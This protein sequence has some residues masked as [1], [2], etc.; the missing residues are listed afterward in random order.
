MSIKRTQMGVSPCIGWKAVLIVGGGQAAR[1][2]NVSRT[3]SH[4]LSPKDMENLTTYL[5][6]DPAGTSALRHG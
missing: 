5:S 1:A 2:R 3:G 6:L 4:L